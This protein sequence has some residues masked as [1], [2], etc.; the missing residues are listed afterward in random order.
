MSAPDATLRLQRLPRHVLNP[1]TVRASDSDVLCA[2]GGLLFFTSRSWPALS[3]A[4]GVTRGDASYSRR[5][6]PFAIILDC[7][8]ISVARSTRCVHRLRR[9]LPSRSTREHTRPPALGFFLRKCRKSNAKSAHVHQNA[10]EA[11]RFH[12]TQHLHIALRAQAPVTT[13][14]FSCGD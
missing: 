9:A 3:A 5:E 1:Q 2:F 7:L 13:L 6:R 11:A 8:D 14:D 10:R 4:S 12:R